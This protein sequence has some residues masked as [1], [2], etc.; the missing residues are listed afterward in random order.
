MH[1]VA[2]AFDVILVLIRSSSFSFILTELK[3]VMMNMMNLNAIKLLKINYFEI[4]YSRR[5]HKIK[6]KFTWI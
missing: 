2:S 4:N 1:Y 6:L 5:N 3:N